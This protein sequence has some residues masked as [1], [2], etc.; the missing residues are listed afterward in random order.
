MI[1]RRMWEGKEVRVTAVG[2]N[3]EGL[4]A[5]AYAGGGNIICF[6]SRIIVRCGHC[7]RWMKWTLRT[8]C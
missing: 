2:D 1:L 3:P 8:R 7:G 4:A 5:G 6:S